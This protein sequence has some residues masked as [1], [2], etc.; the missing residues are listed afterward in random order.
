[1]C[2]VQSFTAISPA[3]LPEMPSGVPST[4]MCDSLSKPLLCQGLGNKCARELSS[5]PGMNN[6]LFLLVYRVRHAQCICK[7]VFMD[8]WNVLLYAERSSPW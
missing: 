8:L 2:S 3:F 7:Q 5:N 4:T 6:F 1:V